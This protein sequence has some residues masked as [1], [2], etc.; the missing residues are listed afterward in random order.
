[1]SPLT[2]AMVTAAPAAHSSTPIPQTKP[3]INPMVYVGTLGVFLGAG[4][5]TLSGR[6]ISVGLADLRGALGFGFDEAAWITT[7]FSMAQMFMGPFSVYLGALLGTRRVLL[8]SGTVFIIASLLL[9]FSPGLGVMLFLQ[10]VSGLSSGTFYPLTMSY[11]LRFLPMRYTI[12]GI[13]VYSMDILAATS[14]AVPLEAWYVEHLSWRWLFWH[15][16]LATP[17]MMLCIHRAVPNPPPRPGPKPSLSWRGFLYASLGVSLLYGVLDQGERLD[18]LNS[19]V[20]VGMLASG[21]FLILA[22]VIRRWA[23]PNPLVNLPFLAHRNTLILAAS[24]FSFRFVLLAIA[25]LIPSFLGAIQN[26][27]ALETGKVMTWVALPQLVMGFLTARLMKRVDGRLILALGF[28]TVA[29]A[30]LMNAQLTTA[31]ASGNFWASQLVMAVGLSFA[32]VGMVGMFVQQAIDTGAISRPFDVLTYS[33]F[34]HM[35]RL[36]GGELGTAT[37]QRLVAVREQ[38]H[39]NVIGLHVEAGAWLTDERLRMLTGGMTPGSSGQEE[40]QRRAVTLLGG[41]VRQQAY[42]LAIA[43]GFITIAWVAVGII[44]LIALMRKMKIFFDSPSMEAPG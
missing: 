26:Y 32:F 30:C 11:A 8:F 34:I 15:S 20:I 3:G 12:Y 38:F 24:L 17:L 7:A 37:M 41:Q 14:L 42:A 39:S 21:I 2:M 1:M 40:A 33:S 9:P 23:S 18:W 13:G 5:S 29:L 35:V 44:V 36:F 16:A 19:G 43:D 31:W 10:V 6:L 28:T 4:I 25:F 27:R 22:S